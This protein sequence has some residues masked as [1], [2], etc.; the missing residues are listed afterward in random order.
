MKLLDRDYQIMREIDRWRFCLS[1]HIKELAGFT[2][3]RACDRRLKL[4]IE[5][6]YIARKKV[7]YGVPNIYYLTNRGKKTIEVTVRQEKI[8]VDRIQHD[9]AV[10]DTVMYFIS[11][12]NISLVEITTEKQLYSRSGFGTRKHCPDFIFTK[13]TGDVC[14]EIELSL[15]AKHRL[16]KI[17]ESNYMSYETQYWVVPNRECKIHSLLQEFGQVYP[18]IEIMTTEEVKRP[19]GNDSENTD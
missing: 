1:R 14:V 8:R 7:L 17:V 11:K 13:D 9:I 6:G 16:Q 4:L 12:E 19:Y 5:A 18:N 15:K 3:Q 10:L 2:G